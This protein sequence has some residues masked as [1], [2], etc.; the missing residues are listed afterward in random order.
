VANKRTYYNR[1]KKSDDQ[2]G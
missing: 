2:E 1:I